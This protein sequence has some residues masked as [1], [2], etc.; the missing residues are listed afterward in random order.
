M[1][2]LQ[3][4]QVW[5]QTGRTEC[6]TYSHTLGFSRNNSLVQVTLLT[7]VI[8]EYFLDFLWLK[9]HY[10]QTCICFFLLLHTRCS[11]ELS[12]DLCTFSLKTRSTMPV[13][14][15]VHPERER[16]RRLS[17][18][19]Q[20]C[21]RKLMQSGSVSCQKLASSIDC[22]SHCNPAGSTNSFDIYVLLIIQATHK[23]SPSA[24]ASS[25]F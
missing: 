9:V 10:G 18:Y 24:T 16:E 1:F 17:H 20:I 6:W 7:I 5:Q 25:K 3:S 13:R 14:V 22:G 11:C 23:L 21:W 2:A 4:A 15:P 19:C 12:C 8:T